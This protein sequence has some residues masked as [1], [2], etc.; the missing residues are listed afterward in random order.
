MVDVVRKGIE[1][2]FACS[3]AKNVQGNEIYSSHYCIVDSLNGI[4]IAFVIDVP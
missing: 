3:L 2:P 4:N 1:V